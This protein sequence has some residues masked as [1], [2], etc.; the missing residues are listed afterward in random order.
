MFI[1]RTPEN[2]VL[3]AFTVV[4]VILG[5]ITYLAISDPGHAILVWLSEA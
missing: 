3:T 4:T 2:N 5:Y 1:G